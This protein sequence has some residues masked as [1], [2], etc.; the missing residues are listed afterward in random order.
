MWLKQNPVWIYRSPKPAAA[1]E[2]RLR[3]WPTTR[4]SRKFWAG[5]RITMTSIPSCAPR[6][7]GKISGCR[8]KPLIDALFNEIQEQLHEN[9]DFRNRLCWLGDGC[10]PGG[11]GAPRSVYGCRPGQDRKAEERPDPH[12]RAGPG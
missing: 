1:P 7:P 2:T 3:R 4:E 5:S 6:W 12:L 10:L 9:H 11:R 8:K